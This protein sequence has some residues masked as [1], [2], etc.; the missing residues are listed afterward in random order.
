M[1][2]AILAEQFSGGRASVAVRNNSRYE[3][4]ETS[5]SPVAYVVAY[6]G[7]HGFIPGYPMHLCIILYCA[8]YMGILC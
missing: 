7:V 2:P 1:R 6:S 5:Y 3:S 4:S 8:I